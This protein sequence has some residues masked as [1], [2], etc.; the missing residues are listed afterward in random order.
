MKELSENFRRFINEDI[1]SRPK[2]ISHHWITHGYPVGA[3]HR[4]GEVLKHTLT[5]SGKIDYY[6]VKFDDGIEV[7][8]EDE[9][10]GVTIQEH[11]HEAAAKVDDDEEEVEEAFHP[12]RGGDA[13]AWKKDDTENLDE[14]WPD[15]DEENLV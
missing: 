2:S 10:I 14:Q 4:I 1:N 11:S 6:K 7:L 5:E 8:K 13:P 3:P 15:S 9:F 12:G